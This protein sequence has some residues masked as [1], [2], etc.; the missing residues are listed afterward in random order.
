MLPSAGMK[1][2]SFVYAAP[3]SAEDVLDLLARHG[4]SA[5]VLAGGQS[6]V[7]M[8]NLRLARPS[9]L[10]DINRVP[11]LDRL[12]VRD[13]QLCLGATVRH[14]D[15]ETR[16]GGGELG[17]LLARVAGHIGHLPIRVRGTVAGSLA[18]ADPNAEWPVAAT[19]LG[20]TLVLASHAGRRL[21][22]AEDF[23]AFPFAP[24]RSAEELL[25]EV[26]IPVPAAGWGG[27]FAEY[28]TTA[29][30]FPT[31]VVC[32]AVWVRGGEVAGCRVAAAGVAGRPVRLAAVEA[33][34]TGRP[35]E[36]LGTAA[37]AAVEDVRASRPA[38]AG[39]LEA[40]LVALTGTALDQAAGVAVAGTAGAGGDR[41][42]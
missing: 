8:M 3:E 19:A 38:A 11:G 26:R 5:A 16:A 23:F 35:A 18:H 2:Q 29:G 12:E 9:V 33:A 20:A 4:A 32:A 24:D 31:A 39:H 14:R 27:G 17:S 36:G 40:L 25:L 7:P 41:W 28:A 22:A 37:E 13:G 6:L 10:V 42:S 1:P 34:A 21:V 15:L 30:A